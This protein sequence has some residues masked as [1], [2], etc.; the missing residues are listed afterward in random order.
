MR[1]GNPDGEAGDPYR[2]GGSP[3]GVYGLLDHIVDCDADH[4]VCRTVVC[5]IY[6]LPDFEEERATM[7]GTILPPD[8]PNLYTITDLRSRI[9]Q[10]RRY[11]ASVVVSQYMVPES[12]GGTGNYLFV[13]TETTGT[14]KAGRPP[15]HLVEVA[16]LICDNTGEVVER[17]GRIVRPDGFTIPASA[18]RI[19]GVTTDYARYAG[20]PLRDA[21]DALA[22]AANRGSVL[23]THNLRFDLAV[24]AGECRRIGIPDP[25]SA[26]PGICT[27][28]STASFCR[29]RRGSGYKWP[30]LSELHQALFG[31]P[32]EDAHRAASDAEACA[33]CFFAL[34]KMGFW[35]TM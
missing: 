22:L 10:Q 17:G 24:I 11:I 5:D 6:L 29:I 26:L 19:H 14:L 15:P 34:K 18:S 1:T 12:P 23:V 2:T 35:K 33:R 9:R 4:R 8:K 13:D 27:M 28:E 3:C 7:A 31:I 30:T 16:W 32:C 25:L 21:L 20:V